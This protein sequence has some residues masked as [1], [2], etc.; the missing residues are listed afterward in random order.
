MRVLI[1]LNVFGL[2]FKH[3]QLDTDI[4]VTIGVQIKFIIGFTLPTLITEGNEKCN[5]AKLG[6]GF[7]PKVLIKLICC[8]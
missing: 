3:K 6:Q 1:Y 8:N 5:F 4:R 2:C 7:F